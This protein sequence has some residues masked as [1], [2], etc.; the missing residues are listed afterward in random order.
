[1]T[2]QAEQTVSIENQNSKVEELAS[3]RSRLDFM[4]IPYQPNAGVKKLRGLVAS[5]IEEQAAPESQVIPT[6]L[7]ELAN[8]PE[9]IGARRARK[10]R[11]ASALVRIVVSCMNP[12]KRDWLG[13][14]YSVGNSAVGQFKKFIPFNNEAGYHVPQIIVNHLLEKECQIFVNRKN[15][16]GEDTKEGRLIKELN[17][18]I[19]APLTREELDELGRRQDATHAIDK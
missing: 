1:M 2:E 18:Q 3:L 14:Q 4:N 17:V 5:G 19:L 11:E 13:E 8:Q 7:P 12:E 9:T 15:A 16:R 10:R 6:P